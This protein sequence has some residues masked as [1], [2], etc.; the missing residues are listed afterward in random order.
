MLFWYITINSK[1]LCHA[2]ILVNWSLERFLDYYCYITDI[3]FALLN[4]FTI[5]CTKNSVFFTAIP[6]LAYWE[7]SFWYTAVNRK[8]KKEI[9]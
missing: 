4:T 3:S 1:G 6:T 2:L 9:K 8:L 7:M 5:L